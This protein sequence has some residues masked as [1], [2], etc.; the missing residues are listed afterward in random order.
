MFKLKQMARA[1]ALVAGIGLG[2]AQSVMAAPISVSV[3]GAPLSV[4]SG[5][6]F[7]VDIVVSGITTE[8]VSA[9][10]ID[11]AYDPSLLFA[12]SFTT[13]L[14]PFGGFGFTDNDVDFTIPGLIDAYLVSFLSDLD[15]TDL[16]CPGA[17]CS[18][19]LTIASAS[20]T[21]LADGSPLVE[22]VNWGD[23]NDVKGANN[24]VIFGNAPEPVPEPASLAL[25]GI[26]M[27]GM[28]AAPVLRRRKDAAKA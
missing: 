7:S 9:W 19:S 15:L 10:D 11:V 6:F 28:L 4:N 22:L 2:M 21:A 18:P 12:D 5:D 27:V 13:Y 3:V 14:G 25:V 16:Q 20:F 23:T 17:V 24:E 1:A 26:A 8:I